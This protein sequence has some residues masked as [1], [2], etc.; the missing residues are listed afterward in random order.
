[1]GLKAAPEK[2]YEEEKARRKR[3]GKQVAPRAW[4]QSERY[5]GRWKGKEIERE[6]TGQKVSESEPIR[7]Q[8]NAR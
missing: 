1:V 4:A 8:P 3:K 2:A 7:G 5:R 6:E